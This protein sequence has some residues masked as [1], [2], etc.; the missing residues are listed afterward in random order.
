[1][2]DL[3]RSYLESL[4]TGELV[5]LADNNGID[6]PPGLER[7][8]IIEEL[9]ENSAEPE[10]EDDLIQSHGHAE[11]VPLPKQYN[12]SFID[13]FIRDPLWVFVIWEIKSHD[14]EIFEKAANFNGYCLRIVPLESKTQED[15]F[16][17]AIEADDSSRYLGFAEQSVLLNRRYVICLNAVRGDHEIQIAVSQPFTLPELKTNES[18]CDLSQNPLVRLSG[19]PD[20]STIKPKDFTPRSKRQ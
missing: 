1:M 11:S 15:S 3:S 4:S 7:I 9:L 18:I 16:S 10:P 12:I 2:D 17:I 8:F 20:L 19:A 14:R 5:K 6:I 13:V